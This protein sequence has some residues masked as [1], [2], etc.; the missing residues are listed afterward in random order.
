MLNGDDPLSLDARLAGELGL[1]QL[2]LAA[3]IA[4]GQTE[5][6]GGGGS[7]LHD[8][9]AAAVRTP[10]RGTGGARKA[11]RLALT[12]SDALIVEPLGRRHGREAFPS[13]T[14]IWHAGSPGYSTAGDADI[15]LGF[16]MLSALSIDLASL[17]CALISRLAVD[18]PAHG[19]GLGRMLLADAVKRSL[20]AGE[21]VAMH[22]L[23]VDAA[24]DDAK[25]FCERF[26]FLRLSHAALQG[27]KG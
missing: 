13:G 7:D 8:G 11:R 1:A 24:N 27:L 26:D 10:A 6:R 22:A 23:I 12:G 4:D 21:T 16:H 5:A 17:P 14:A 3:S 25:R 18:R 15:V 9:P 2:E 19:C 20:A